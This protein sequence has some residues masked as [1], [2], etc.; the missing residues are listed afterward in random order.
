MKKTIVFLFAVFLSTSVLFAGCGDDEK[1]KL[2]GNM[3]TDAHATT[4]EAG[5]VLHSLLDQDNC[6]YE[7][8]DDDEEQQYPLAMYECDSSGVILNKDFY[9]YDKNG[10]EIKH[11]HYEGDIFDYT[12]IEEYDKNN[13]QVKIITYAGEEKRENLSQT[14]VLKY[15]KNGNVIECR[16]Y[17]SDNALDNYDITKYLTINGEELIKSVTSYDNTNNVTSKTI[18]SYRSDGTNSQD[19]RTV[20]DNDGKISYKAVTGY[21]SE[22][23]ANDYKFYDADGNEIDDPESDVE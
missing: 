16:A 15:N 7:Y 9:E 6:Y 13:N 4:D 14:L 17:D 12:E 10:N 1:K 18:Y 11:I 5:R 23:T 8:A 3:V 22:G 21:D 20:Y 2:N 19:V